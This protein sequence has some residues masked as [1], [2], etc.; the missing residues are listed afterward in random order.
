VGDGDLG[1]EHVWEPGTEADAPVLLLLHGTGGDEGDLLPLGRSLAAD[2]SL[3][4]P[5][6]KVLEGTMPRWF[7]R[8]AEGVFDEADLIERAHELVSF[9]DAASDHYGFARD[10]VVAVGFSNGANMAA[11]VMLLDPGALRGGVL[12]SPMVPLR[13]EVVPDLSGTA[14]LIG[15]GRSDPIA[16]PGQAA[17]LAMLLTD[18]GASVDL[19]WHPGGHAVTPE[20]VERARGWLA[21]LRTAIGSRPVRGAPHAPD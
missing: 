21:R 13:P 2:S 20:E 6:G 19:M 1:F 17:A 16:P 7:R 9:V 3:L 18:S 15:A 14:V 11:A 8:L 10:K 4:S 12:L 5:R